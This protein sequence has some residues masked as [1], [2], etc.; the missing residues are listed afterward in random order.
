MDKKFDDNGRYPYHLVYQDT[1]SPQRELPDHVHNWFELVYVH[2]GQ[3]VFFINQTFYD[4]NEGSLFLIPG[5]T[6]HRAFPDADAPVTSSAIFFNASWI[7][8]GEQESDFSVLRCFELAARNNRYRLSLSNEARVLIVK[9][10]QFMHEEQL[11]QKPG[12]RQA[13]FLHLQQFLLFMTRHMLD[14]NKDQVPTS[15]SQPLWMKE[16]LQYIDRN[17][18]ADLRLASLC[19]KA[20]V[21][22]SHFSRVFRQLT[23]MTLTDYVVAKRVVYAK[24]LLIRTDDTSHDIAVQCGFESSSY[25]F[26]VFKKLT[27]VT[28]LHY[29][30]T[31]R[32]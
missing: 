5:D 26:K 20:S 17:L 4:M 32:F 31:N 11:Q 6:I 24:E 7:R 14:Q 30:K 13:T 16:S 1:K 9:H 10:L 25:F 12:Y 22:P 23:G 21:T 27:G 2:H 3:G 28:P 19:K 18:S 8:Q 29:R 15:A